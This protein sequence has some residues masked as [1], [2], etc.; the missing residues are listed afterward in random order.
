MIKAK[1]RPNRRWKTQF[2]G[3]DNVHSIRHTKRNNRITNDIHA[4][5]HDNRRT[6][7]KR[8][9]TSPSIMQWYDCNLPFMILQ[10][11]VQKH[12]H[13]KRKNQH[14]R[15]SVSGWWFM[16]MRPNH[17]DVKLNRPR[18]YRAN[19]KTSLLNN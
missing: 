5:L 3:I 8:I 9:A 18:F 10:R 7:R 6:M 12:I 1:K 2:S 15:L 16:R 17:L 19:L 4:L 13:C 14:Y 11:Y